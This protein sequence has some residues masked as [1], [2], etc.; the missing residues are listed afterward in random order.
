MRSLIRII[1]VGRRGAIPAALF[2][3]RLRADG[4][5][6]QSGALMTQDICTGS[7][8]AQCGMPVRITIHGGVAQ[9]A[10]RLPSRQHDVGSNPTTRSLPAPVFKTQARSLRT[11]SGYSCCRFAARAFARRASAT[12]SGRSCP[13]MGSDFLEPSHNRRIWPS[14]RPRSRSLSNHV[15]WRQVRV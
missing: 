7:T 12:R 1:Q 4:A 9:L 14:T 2:R 6:G 8:V 11:R 13:S 15:T 10:E 5:V 3:S